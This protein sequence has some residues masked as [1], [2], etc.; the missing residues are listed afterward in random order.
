[1]ARPQLDVVNRPVV[2]DYVTVCAASLLPFVIV[3]DAVSSIPQHSWFHYAGASLAM[4]WAI[5]ASGRRVGDPMLFYGKASA[6]EHGTELEG[7]VSTGKSTP[8]LR[9]TKDADR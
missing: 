5:V 4:C 1:M 8:D 9:L 3:V 7:T 2:R 6:T